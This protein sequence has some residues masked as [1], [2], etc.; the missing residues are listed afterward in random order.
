MGSV[1]VPQLTRVCGRMPVEILA[2]L[3]C[4]L[5]GTDLRP[6]G[7]FLPCFLL[8]FPL[9]LFLLYLASSDPKI[10][11]LLM[12]ENKVINLNKLL[13]FFPPIPHV[14]TLSLA[15]VMTL[16]SPPSSVLSVFQ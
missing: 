14:E 12:L 16:S 8:F 2:L 5:P 10:Y 11:T 15:W 13:P 3:L 1:Q 6:L 4:T 7:C 9:P